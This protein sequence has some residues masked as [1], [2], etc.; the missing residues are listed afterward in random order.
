M[1]KLLVVL[2][3]ASSMAAFADE[4][5]AQNAAVAAPN[6]NTMSTMASNGNSNGGLSNLYIGG[7]A[8]AAWNNVQ[9]PA[10]SFRADGGYNFNPYWA[11]EAGTTGVTQ[12]GGKGDQSMQFY[13][14]SIK[15]TIP[16]GDVFGVFAQLGGAYGSPGQIGAAGASLNQ[17]QAGWDVLTAVGLQL[18]V[19]QQVSL[20][21]TDYYYY[22]AN[23]PQGDTNVLLAG[24]KYNF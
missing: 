7:G 16:M 21:L 18:N 22:G 17:A 23:G 4:P 12:S 19:T 24:L 20:N 9:A 3:A 14:L 11:F 6:N 8:G 1:K 5:A 2:L 15:G 10:A 13:D